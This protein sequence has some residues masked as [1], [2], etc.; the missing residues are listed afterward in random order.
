M[1]PRMQSLPVYTLAMDD[2]TRKHVCM[3]ENCFVTFEQ[4]RT[5]LQGVANMQQQDVQGLGL[6]STSLRQANAAP[7][8]IGKRPD[9]LAQQALD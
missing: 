6:L 7:H 5:H 3:E 2:V 1:P 8:A 9:D 4:C